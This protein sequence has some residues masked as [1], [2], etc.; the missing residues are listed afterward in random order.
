M[1][2]GAALARIRA[3]ARL[4]R[5]AF[6]ALGAREA[7]RF[8]RQRFGGLRP[9]QVG[10]LHP[11]DAAHPL[12]A[13]GGSTDLRVFQQ[14]FVEREYG[15][16]DDAAGVELVID[17]GANVGYS[18]AWFLSR[19]PG[20]RVLAVEPDAEN[21]AALR[22]NLAPYGARATLLR[23]GLWSHPCGLRMEES[24][25]RGGGAWA[26]QVRETRPGEE[27]GL[28]AF[29]V[30]SLLERAG[31]ARAS[32]LKIDVEGAEAV[33]FAGA[34]DW[35]DR[36]DNLVIELHDDSHFGDARAAFFRAIEGRG[37]ALGTSGELTVAR[38]AAPAA[39]G[40]SA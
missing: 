24:A 18:S 25:F 35:L 26:R 37:F 30:P 8:L 15:C 40:G 29:D 33:V 36:V 4:T 5:D 22:R 3:G 28:P 19:W 39:G 16:L 12:F 7:A 34:C 23:A 21:F 6:R 10:T 31:A 14:V 1:N 2:T 9:G 27:P 17:C 32:V 38:R 20:A 13:R 11:P